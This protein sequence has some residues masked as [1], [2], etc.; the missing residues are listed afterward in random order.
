MTIQGGC[1]RLLPEVALTPSSGTSQGPPPLWWQPVTQGEEPSG[2]SQLEQRREGKAHHLL[3][4]GPQRSDFGT[5][6]VDPTGGHSLIGP[7]QGR[8]LQATAGCFLVGPFW[9][10]GCITWHV[11][12]WFL[13]QELNPCPLQC[14]LKV[15]TTG[16]P[17][18]S[19]GESS[20]S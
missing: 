11:G 8:H 18:K 1:G 2:P 16:P 9:F 15:L 17:G 6:W 12:S 5:H 7:E 14:E 13:D 20:F 19:P 3:R 10:F 4:P